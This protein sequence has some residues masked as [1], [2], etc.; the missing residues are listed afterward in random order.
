VSEQKT[1]AH[2]PPD[3]ELNVKA[4]VGTGLALL[5]AT[6]L[7]GLLVWWVASFLTDHL[8]AQDAPPPVLREARAPYE[9]PGPRVSTDPAALLHALRAEEDAILETYGW[10][11]ETNEVVRVPIENA[12]EML[13]ETNPEARAFGVETP[14]GSTEATE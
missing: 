5:L 13:L 8:D 1:P 12:M 7:S 3:R 14:D 2:W 6:A 9:P 11:D 10:V 4:I